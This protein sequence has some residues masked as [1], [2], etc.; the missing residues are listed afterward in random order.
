MTIWQFFHKKM[1]ALRDDENGA[2]IIMTL[3]MFLFL[4]VLCISVYAIGTAV[5][6]KMRL[7]DIADAASYSMSVAQADGLSRIATIN[8]AMSWTYIQMTRRQM[9]YIVNN[10]LM[11]TCATF[12]ED[13][14][15]CK[16]WNS[17]TSKALA[18]FKDEG[19]FFYTYFMTNCGKHSSGT[20]DTD[21]STGTYW[22][23]WTPGDGHQIRVD[24]VTKDESQ[25]G[26]DVEPEEYGKFF[27]KETLQ[28]KILNNQAIE[29]LETGIDQDKMALK[30]LDTI[31]ITTCYNTM[32]AMEKSVTQ[33]LENSIPPE[34]QTD[35]RFILK[36]MPMIYPYLSTVYD[37]LIS[38]NSND[39]QAVSVLSPYH[40]TEED[41]LEFLSMTMNTASLHDIFGDGID[42]WFV[43]GKEAT[44]TDTSKVVT[45]DIDN[46]IGQGIQRGYK[47][48]NR[49][50]SGMEGIK[51]S[52]VYRANHV[53]TG[54]I[55]GQ[56]MTA[57]NTI[58][59]LIS[60]SE[61]I[62]PLAAE[63]ITGNIGFGKLM[64]IIQ[65]FM[66]CTADMNPSCFNSTKFFA[67][68]CYDID[69]N[70]GLVS[71]YHWASMRWWCAIETKYIKT[72]FGWY[73]VGGNLNHYKLLP[74][75][76][77]PQHGYDSPNDA[78]TSHTRDEYRPCVIGVDDVSGM[79][80]SSHDSTNK[81][82]GYITA[83]HTRIYGDDK[84]IYN[85]YYTGAKA[86]PVKLNEK[87]FHDANVVVL[88]KRR[89]NPLTAWVFSDDEKLDSGNLIDNS[90]YA[91]F[92]MLR[93][94]SENAISDSDPRWICAI[95]ASR[96]AYR[97]RSADVNDQTYLPG[98]VY[99][100]KYNVM[101]SDQIDKA[102]ES[103][104]IRLRIA[105]DSTGNGGST[106]KLTKYPF[107][108]GCP[109][110]ISGNRIAERL[111][112]TWNL[113]ETD[114][115]AV[116]VPVQY[117]S[118]GYTYL[119]A[120]DGM[121]A[122][123]T[124]NVSYMQPKGAKWDPVQDIGSLMESKQWERLSSIG[125]ETL[126][127]DVLNSNNPSIHYKPSFYTIFNLH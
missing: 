15:K 76:E 96:A 78:F 12:D 104:P 93:K 16:E 2:V 89:R 95:S 50:E 74:L 122:R 57:I 33:I 112:N 56:A 49:K 120:Y 58:T 65:N 75:H 115:D 7:Q 64:G 3:G 34:E 28:E 90:L 38:S 40:N 127:T 37:P 71:E 61:L 88:A 14:D 126:D 73:P 79:I 41:E 94:K 1:L 54:N 10:W 47:T 24:Y 66:S 106:A 84:D 44:L 105:A 97:E 125:K 123:R 62:I 11:K 67:E 80:G 39:S 59:S 108:I 102:N 48:A 100:T 21:N 110:A 18:S 99:Q 114:W 77:C 45:P 68:Q 52:P 6:E 113:C 72:P 111:K 27:S 92:N 51:E 103:D 85:E 32:G 23:G 60:H 25:G 30:F 98:R 116:F 20:E 87:F 109:H 26:G 36:S 22:A 31:M 35:Y 42:Q 29:T 19:S 70:Y 124:N 46:Y 69:D 43:R 53:S 121:Q 91:L 9:D 83:G 13:L 81:V 4:Y 101:S 8:R 119:T 63:G 107:R 118:K 5:E 55:I 86:M 17:K 117:T 82:N